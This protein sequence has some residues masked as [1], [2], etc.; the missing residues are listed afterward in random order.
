[1]SVYC[2]KNT[3]L[4]GDAGGEAGQETQAGTEAGSQLVL[5]HQDVLSGLSPGLLTLLGKA[6]EDDKGRLLQE[7]GVGIQTCV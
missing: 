6:G 3:R 1:M 5:S 2:F 4:K 7:A